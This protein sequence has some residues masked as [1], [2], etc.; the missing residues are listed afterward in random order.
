[1][2]TD[3]WNTKSLPCPNNDGPN[4]VL[5]LISIIASFTL[6]WLLGLEPIPPQPPILV[7]VQRFP[8]P[9]AVV[10]AVLLC[11]LLL[12]LRP[13]VPAIGRSM[14]WLVA[15]KWRIALLIMLAL[16]SI[17]AVVYP[18]L[19]IPF[20]WLVPP[21]P[22]L[23]Y[24]AKIPGPGCAPDSTRW[25]RRTAVTLQCTAHGL[26]MKLPANAVVLGEVSFDPRGL[27]RIETL[28]AS[29]PNYCV[30][31]TASFVTGGANSAVLLGALGQQSQGAIV[32]VVTAQGAVRIV[33][34]DLHGHLDTGPPLAKGHLKVPTRTF[35]LAIGVAEHQIRFWINQVL[36]AKADKV[37]YVITTHVPLAL[38]GGGEPV[39]VLFSDFR[40]YVGNGAACVASPA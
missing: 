5:W 9:M 1:M 25:S 29:L 37:S 24:T 2:Y 31:V 34:Y 40:F 18:S 13:R 38:E 17:T 30:R 28:G 36:V 26:D 11:L 35:L 7:L 20:P 3:P 33:R 22:A 4:F 27:R 14:R 32:G 19:H 6:Q 16:T 39:E 15:A 10:A 8:V 21:V 23:L 12:L